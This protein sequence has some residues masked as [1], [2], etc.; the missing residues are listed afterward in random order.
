[1]ELVLL[2]M[3]RPLPVAEPQDCD[4]RRAVFEQ[5][6][7]WKNATQLL[8]SGLLEYG[9]LVLARQQP[10]EQMAQQEA[11]TASLVVEPF[12]EC[13]LPA[14]AQRLGQM[15]R[16]R[17]RRCRTPTRKERG[18]TSRKDVWLLVFADLSFNVRPVFF[19]CVV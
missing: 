8:A 15:R 17:A 9:L 18:A 13:E 14:F 5:G 6:C 3:S 16:R 10:V 4:L 2:A 12:R 11:A 1:V 19:V 7:S